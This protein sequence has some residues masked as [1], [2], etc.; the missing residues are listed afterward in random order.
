MSSKPIVLPPYINVTKNKAEIVTVDVDKVCEQFSE[1]QLENFKSGKSDL[2]AKQLA[3]SDWIVKG[4]I[5]ADAFI[6]RDTQGKPYLNTASNHISI[7][8]TQ[9][10]LSFIHHPEIEVSVDI[11]FYNREVATISNR[12]T[13]DEEVKIIS[14]CGISNAHIV[15]WSIKECLFKILG[16]RGVHFLSDLRIVGSSCTDLTIKTEC[17][18]KHRDLKL[19]YLVNSFIFEPILLSYIDE[20]PFQ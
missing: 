13:D 2:R 18:V 6:K 14:E 20:P 1:K 7:S 15:I 10:I 17:E 19:R 4:R 3:V 11:E 9:N 8:H 12:F 5:D 16:R